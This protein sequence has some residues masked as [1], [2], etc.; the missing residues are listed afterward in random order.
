M[1]VHV[2]FLQYLL[3]D[4]NSVIIFTFA[5]VIISYLFRGVRKIFACYM[6]LNDM[7]HGVDFE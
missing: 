5:C 6:W 2:Q 3:N 7:N 1:F 4:L